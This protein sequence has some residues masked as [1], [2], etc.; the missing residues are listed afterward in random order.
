M[1]KTFVDKFNQRNAQSRQQPQQ[2]QSQQLQQQQ[3]QL[4]LQQQQ[5]QLQ[6]QQLQQQQLQQQRLQQQQQQQLLQQQHIIQ[7]PQRLA[8]Y[9][10]HASMQQ[11]QAY[12]QHAPMQ[13]Q[14]ASQVPQGW[15]QVTLQEAVSARSNSPHIPL[16]RFRRLHTLLP[17]SAHFNFVTHSFYPALF[18]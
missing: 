17:S 5:Q 4:Q 15:Q 2:Q 13:Q 11:Q 6:Q 18:S 9:T 14:Q 1:T 3:Q 10:Q 8:Q 7:P 12:P 16:V